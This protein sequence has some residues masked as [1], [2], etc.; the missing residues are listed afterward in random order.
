[1]VGGGKKGGRPH[2]SSKMKKKEGVRV[3]PEGEKKRG[4]AA[5]GA[6]VGEKGGKKGRRAGPFRCPKVMPGEGS[7]LYA[8][9]GNS[10][11]CAG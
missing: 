2:L 11:F 10:L 6:G 5:E 7:F 8:V 9:V 1:L 4:W 3:F